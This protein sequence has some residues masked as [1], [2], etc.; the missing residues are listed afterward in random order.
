[1][2]KESFSV[3]VTVGYGLFSTYIRAKTCLSPSF[4]PHSTTNVLTLNKTKQNKN[5]ANAIKNNK[6]GLIVNVC[7]DRE[8]NELAFYFLHPQAACINTQR[9]ECA[10]DTAGSFTSITQR[11]L[12][13]PETT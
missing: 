12:A 6:A 11:Y 8:L 9:G 1:M 2:I 10:A 7:T 13:A 5:P 3:H 4:A